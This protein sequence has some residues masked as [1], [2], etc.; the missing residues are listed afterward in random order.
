MVAAVVVIPEEF[1]DVPWD[2]SVSFGDGGVAWG[3]S[4]V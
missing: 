2:Y 3:G 4:D 1:V